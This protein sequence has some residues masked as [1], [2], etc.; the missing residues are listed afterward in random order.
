MMSSVATKLTSHQRN[1]RTLSAHLP[2]IT[3]SQ[4]ISLASPNFFHTS[5]IVQRPRKDRDPNIKITLEQ[6]RMAARGSGRRAPI[7]HDEQEKVMNSLEAANYENSLIY[8]YIIEYDKC[9]EDYEKNHKGK[10][11]AMMKQLN[12]YLVRTRKK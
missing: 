1:L 11:K 7:C 5:A 2:S 6:L 8:K 12:K 3:S 9:R 10:D 4:T